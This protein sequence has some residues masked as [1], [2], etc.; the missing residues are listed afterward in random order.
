VNHK[1][2]RVGILFR[3]ATRRVTLFAARVV[4]IQL[5]SQLA[6]SIPA[7]A[8]E[9]GSGSAHERPV[10]S[11]DGV[12][13]N[14][15]GAGAPQTGLPLRS[16]DGVAADF[17]AAINDERAQ[18]DLPAVGASQTLERLAHTRAEEIGSSGSLEFES[19]SGDEVLR[20]L[21]GLGYVGWYA[22]EFVSVGIADPREVLE[23]WNERLVGDDGY[24]RH[25]AR[26][27]GLGHGVLEGKPVYVLIV[28]TPS[29]GPLRKRLP[30]VAPREWLAGDLLRAFNDARVRTSLPGFDR[31]PDFDEEAAH[32]A[33]EILAD[34]RLN[35]TGAIPSDVSG[36]TVLYY[37]GDTV[38]VHKPAHAVQTWFQRY[39][40]Q[41]AGKAVRFVGVALDSRGRG[42]HI[43]AVWVL[44]LGLKPVPSPK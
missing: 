23:S 30:G 31:S 34:P 29:A 40:A 7:A 13:Q 44:V 12:S 17:L 10:T 38:D 27:V 4:L 22:D 26:E 21:K 41:V 36:A 28:A 2:G 3:L 6:F 37:K 43:E 19:L 32:R 16:R 24:R 35:G 1:L 25:E 39:R 18:R 9:P 15:P 42:E 33:A 5:S 14:P 8:K 11:V 20:R